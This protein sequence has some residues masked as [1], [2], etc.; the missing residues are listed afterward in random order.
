M[1]VSAC[2]ADCEQ[3]AQLSERLLSH[4]AASSRTAAQPSSA[5]WAA[6]LSGQR[7]AHHSTHSAPSQSYW[8]AAAAHSRDSAARMAHTHS[9][10]TALPGACWRVGMSTAGARFII[11][12]GSFCRQGIALGGRGFASAGRARGFG[13]AARGAVGSCRGHA[14]W[15][16]NAAVQA[17]RMGWN[18]QAVAAYTPKLPSWVRSRLPE[19]PEGEPSTPPCMPALLLLSMKTIL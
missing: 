18:S 16:E 2:R 4:A 5:S 19:M 13:Q 11:S 3:A 8:H 14:T 9:C 1:F 6:R 12:A 7:T 15:A 17:G 10:S